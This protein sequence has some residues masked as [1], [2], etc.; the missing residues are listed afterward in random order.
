MATTTLVPEQ[1]EEQKKHPLGWLLDQIAEQAPGL[2]KEEE[3]TIPSQT[4]AKMWGFADRIKDAKFLPAHAKGDRA[5]VFY[6]LAMA[7]EMGANWTHALRSLY[8]TPD[9]KPGIQGD[10][11]LALLLSKNFRVFWPVQDDTRAVCQICRPKCTCPY[12]GKSHRVACTCGHSQEMEVTF[13]EMTAMGFTKN[14]DGNLKYNWRNQKNMLRWRS[15]AFG[16]RFYAAD[17]LGGLYLLEELEE[18][19]RQPETE[20]EDR[21]ETVAQAAGT[22]PT[23]PPAP[24]ENIISPELETQFR[25]AAFAAG[26]KQAWV[27]GQIAIIEGE[28]RAA[29]AKDPKT[30][31]PTMAALKVGI[32][33]TGLQPK[34]PRTRAQQARD[35]EAQREADAQG[36]AAEA[37]EART[38]LDQEDVPAPAPPASPAP[39]KPS[40]F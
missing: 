9:G 1:Q 32:A 4:L 3:G 25:E 15:F 20:P 11:A 27:A 17:V 6:L 35:R 33:M 38:A 30:D 40:L 22:A 39:A 24:D 19:A 16:Y 18:L 21:M 36:A 10:F 29:L 34:K 13:S 37:M 12:D 5:S 7:H 23:S 26:K 31:V 2:I 28:I 14:K 8:M